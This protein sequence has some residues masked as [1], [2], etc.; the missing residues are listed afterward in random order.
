MNSLSSLLTASIPSEVVS[1]QQKS[2]VTYSLSLL[3]PQDPPTITLLEARNLVAAAG[4]T[5]MR[6]WEAALHL[7]NYLS[8]QQED[9]IDGKSVLE[10][11]TG[12]GYISILCAKHLG[13]A[14]VL[15]TDGSEDVVS[16]LS[17]NLLLNGLQ[18]TSKIQTK[19]LRWGHVLASG[20]Q[21][22]WNG[23][24]KVDVV[25]GADITYDESGIVPLVATFEDLLQLFPDVK[26]IISATIRNRRTF[27]AFVNICRSHGYQV[28]EIDFAT[29]PAK[30]QMGPFSSDAVPIKICTI[31]KS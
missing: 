12:T 18:N 15:A 24:R 31:N 30:E 29:T 1:I 14:Y 26:I 5:G 10:L 17:T 6:T 25:L 27:K 13:A 20:E 4:T 16:G 11:G 21:L 19:E 2:Y 8:T 23:G 7:G 28:E 3:S 9:L 22:E